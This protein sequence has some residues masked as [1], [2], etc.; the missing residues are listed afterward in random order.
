MLDFKTNQKLKEFA[1]S[2][3]QEMNDS[4]LNEK[5]FT[6][7]KTEIKLFLVR[8]NTDEAEAYNKIPGAFLGASLDHKGETFLVFRTLKATS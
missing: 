1:E 4:V 8:N 6:I 3:A 2:V 5:Q 7:P